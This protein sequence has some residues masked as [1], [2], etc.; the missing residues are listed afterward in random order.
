MRGADAG[1]GDETSLR[2]ETKADALGVTLIA[3]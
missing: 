3:A 2:P 1:I